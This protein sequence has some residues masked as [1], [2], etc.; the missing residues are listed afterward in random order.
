M[1]HLT[2]AQHASLVE[3][4]SVRLTLKPLYVSLDRNF[5]MKGA[6]WREGNPLLAKPACVGQCYI[7]DDIFPNRS[8]DDGP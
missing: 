6:G 3:K 8:D 2:H 1:R 4:S 7:A 5:K